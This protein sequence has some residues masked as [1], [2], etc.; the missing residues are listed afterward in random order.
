MRADDLALEERPNL[1]NAIGMH[2]RIVAADILAGAMVDAVTCGHAVGPGWLSRHA[3]PY[4]RR[5][6]GATFSRMTWFAPPTRVRFGISAG[7]KFA[8]ALQHT[9]DL[10]LPGRPA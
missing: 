2:G 1:L 6:S 10:A 4:E 5:A 8:A 3:R 9:Y 7:A